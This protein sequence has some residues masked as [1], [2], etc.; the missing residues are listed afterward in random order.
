MAESPLVTLARL[1]AGTVLMQ[2]R[3]GHQV[4]GALLVMNSN[5]V[6]VAAASLVITGTSGQRSA[7]GQIA[8]RTVAPALAVRTLLNTQEERIERRERRL[9]ERERAWTERRMA[10]KKKNRELRAEVD[11]LRALARTTTPS[12]PNPP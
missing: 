4:L 9:A 1:L 7:V 8:L 10:I 11:R 12:G 2:G 5:E 3:L 6:A